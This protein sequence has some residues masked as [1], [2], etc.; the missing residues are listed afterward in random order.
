MNIEALEIN[1]GDLEKSPKTST[2]NN[3]PLFMI[4]SSVI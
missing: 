2:A 4:E 1:K 3:W